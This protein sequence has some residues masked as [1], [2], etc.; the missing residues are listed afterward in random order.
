M[1]S[2]NDDT[3]HCRESGVA[4]GSQR[5]VMVMT[6]GTKRLFADSE[7]EERERRYHLSE[8]PVPMVVAAYRIIVDCNEIF[9]EQ[10]GYE[11]RE[12]VNGSFRRLYAD[13]K[14]FVLV[15]ELWATHL[16]S[17]RVYFDERVM[18]RKDNG[19][20]WC[21]V[22]GRSNTPADPFAEAIYCFEPMQRGVS[23]AEHVLTGRQRQILMLVA[24]G[25]SNDLIAAELGLSRR[26]VE[27]H[28]ARLMK[29]VGV[30]NGAE[31]MAWFSEL[32]GK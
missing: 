4:R 7:P 24:R 17:G 26:T 21:R 16:G 10:F 22:H 20:F 11:R 18:R 1:F 5:E 12:L 8:L 27:A 32:E 19:R 31:L 6:G 13:T 30:H 15:G 25:L 29:A 9:A 23:P 28:R 14:E 3:F 2:S